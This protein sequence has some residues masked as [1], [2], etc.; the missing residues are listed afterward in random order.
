[1][2]CLELRL[3]RLGNQS[4][5]ARAQDFGERIIDGPFLTEASGADR[6]RR[7]DLASG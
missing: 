7:L 5:R 3:Y 4:T 1:M 6:E 2:K